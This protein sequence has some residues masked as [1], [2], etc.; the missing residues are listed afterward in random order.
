ML[1]SGAHI[2]LWDEIISTHSRVFLAGNSGSFGGVR[3]HIRS[4]S[5]G[6]CGATTPPLSKNFGLMGNPGLPVSGAVAV[7]DEGLRRSVTVH[8]PDDPL[9]ELADRNHPAQASV[10]FPAHDPESRNSL[11]S[12][13]PVAV[14]AVAA[15]DPLGFA[16]DNSLSRSIAD[17]YG[18]GSKPCRE[19][20]A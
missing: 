3:D 19:T 1:N 9:H 10:V 8:L 12:E 11:A 7:P 18:D 20:S 2:R 16:H 6:P 17:D 15:L 13:A 4:G 14:F 5:S